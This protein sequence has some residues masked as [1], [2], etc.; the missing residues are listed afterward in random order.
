M[1][2]NS[3]LFSSAEKANTASPSPIKKSNFSLDTIV[4]K[5]QEQE[6]EDDKSTILYTPRRGRRVGKVDLGWESPL[7]SFTCSYTSP[8]KGKIK[9]EKQQ[10]QPASSTFGSNIC[11]FDA[12]GRASAAILKPSFNHASDANKTWEDVNNTPRS[13]QLSL[14][15]SPCKAAKY[16]KLAGFHRQSLLD[17]PALVSVEV[18]AMGRMAVHRSEA[19]QI[20]CIDTSSLTNK[21]TSGRGSSS[22][23][24]TNPS[25]F[26][27]TPGLTDPSPSFSLSSQF[28][29]SEPNSSTKAYSKNQTMTC[30][31]SMPISVEATI[32]LLR[33]AQKKEASN[34]DTTPLA[35]KPRLIGTGMP[36]LNWP[37]SPTG[38]WSSAGKELQRLQD[39]K[40]RGIARW[41]DED[42]EDEVTPGNG[43]DR[44]HPMVAKAMHDRARKEMFIRSLSM[45]LLRQSKRISP[46]KKSNNNSRRKMKMESKSRKKQGSDSKTVY[47]HPPNV[48]GRL[49]EKQHFALS[50]SLQSSSVI[51]C[52]CGNKTDEGGLAM[53]MCDACNLWFH[54]SCM[55]I[56]EQELGEEW[57]CHICCDMAASVFSPNSLG[58]DR[59]SLIATPT[60]PRLAAIAG[61]QLRPSQGQLPVFAQPSSES[62][63]LRHLEQNSLPIHGFS[64]GI[65]LAPSPTMLSHDDTMERRSNSTK[66]HRANRVGWHQAEPDSP[67]ERKSGLPFTHRRSFSGNTSNHA[68][69]PRKRV[70]TFEQGKWTIDYTPAVGPPRTPSPRLMS[71][72][73]SRS[74]NVSARNRRESSVKDLD[75]IFS[76]PSRILQGSAS[77]GAH[78]WQNSANGNATLL[79]HSREDSG[80]TGTAGGS[81]ST[82]WGLSTPTRFMN[83]GEFSS[84]QSDGH[85]GLPSLVFSSGG[86]DLADLTW[87]LQSPS[88]STRAATR[89]RQNSSNRRVVGNTSSIREKTPVHQTSSHTGGYPSSSPF[90]KTP[91]FADLMHHPH[92]HHSPL[93]SPQN[94]SSK[95]FI[96]L[97]HQMT[98]TAANPGLYT[99]EFNNDH[100][101]SKSTKSR[102]A[103]AAAAHVKARNVSSG[104]LMAGLGIG[105]DLEDVLDWA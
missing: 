39:Q 51:G 65:A 102:Q 19:N 82:P 17:L 67:L 61:Q 3:S 33:D 30:L 91:T 8:R 80:L 100:S 40:K 96:R 18:P 87:Q 74:V 50:P 99:A 54:L 35:W 93:H 79:R 57:F 46:T 44:Q 66:R 24:C 9:I 81:S 41:L 76:T 36:R 11:L 85:G 29:L 77:W 48:V 21:S 88:S 23:S 1:T 101:N 34:F 32:Q 10:Q 68:P 64:S 60:F 37:D 75:D 43:H 86:L 71:S 14:Q 72:S 95:N 104:E 49:A 63:S 47:L 15:E 90:P 52:V 73:K 31:L 70:P 25:S 20:A 22:S 26:D 53:V 97:S 45:P 38:P 59:A 27:D 28:P 105:L 55:G 98:P 7:P 5:Q 16:D 103:N 69:S 84:D 83:S 58:D 56:V 62:P 13:R 78:H 42:S 2:A 92:H 12:Q 89:A 94:T 6:D 4:G